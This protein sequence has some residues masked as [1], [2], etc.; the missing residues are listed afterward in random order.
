MLSSFMAGFILYHFEAP[1]IWWI[2]FIIIM[3]FEIL[4]E[5]DQLDKRRRFKK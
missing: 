4:Y 2:G 1:A 5:L 3:L